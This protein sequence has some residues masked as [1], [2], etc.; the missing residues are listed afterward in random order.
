[1]LGL[2]NRIYYSL[3]RLQLAL[4]RAYEMEENLPR[5]NAV[6]ILCLFILMKLIALFGVLSVVL[7]YP[8]LI[9]SKLSIV[10]VG[11]ITI[12]LTFLYIFYRN[13]YEKIEKQMAAKWPTEKVWNILLTIGYVILT[14]IVLLFSIRYI[15][16][17]PFKT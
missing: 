5:T 11:L 4:A 16:H 17:N 6:L 13:H 15:K 9:N 10:A 2:F 14:G 3:F 8:L 7:G 1:M 12:T